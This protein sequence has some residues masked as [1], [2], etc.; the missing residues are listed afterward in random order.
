VL[1]PE[2]GVFVE[3]VPGVEG[4]VVVLLPVAFAVHDHIGLDDDGVPAGVAQKLE[5]DFIVPVGFFG[6]RLWGR[7]LQENHNVLSQY[8]EWVSESSIYRN[9]ITN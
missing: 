5:I 2:D 9:L 4:Q 8:H 3:V 7:K 1:V 6:L